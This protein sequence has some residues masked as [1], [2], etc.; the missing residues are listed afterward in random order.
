MVDAYLD[1]CFNYVHYFL[2][3]HDVCK[4]LNII[5]RYKELP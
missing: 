2:D 3:H 4:T 1:I 5:G